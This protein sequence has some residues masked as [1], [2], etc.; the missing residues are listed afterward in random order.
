[1]TQLEKIYCVV[2]DTCSGVNELLELREVDTKY[3]YRLPIN[4]VH[5]AKLIKGQTY[6]FYKEHNGLGQGPK[7]SFIQ[8]G[9]EIGQTKELV[10]KETLNLNNGK[11]FILEND[12]GLDLKVKSLSFQSQHR[13]IKCQ[14]INYRF[15]KPILNNIDFD[16][17]HYLLDNDYLFDIV[18]FG[19]FI[20]KKGLS[21]N[22]VILKD[23]NDN[24]I[25]VRAKKWQTEK[26]WK[27]KN[28]KCKI[29]GY[30]QGEI[31]KVHNIDE[32]HPY[33]EVGDIIKFEVT[34]FKERKIEGEPIIRLI[35]LKDKYNYS[36]EV[37]LLPHQV[38]KLKIG[39]HIDCRVER[40]SH[41]V[42][43]KQVI[44]DD[45][46]F[47]DFKNIIQNSNH[48]KKYFSPQFELQTNDVNTLQMRGQYE[49]RSGFYILTF[50]NKILPNLFRNAIDRRDY[51]SAIEI[52]QLIID[53]EKWILKNGII[54]AFPNEL[55]RKTTRE[56]VKYS[57]ERAEVRAKILPAIENG[58]IKQIV[59]DLQTTI[60]SAYYIFL[61]SDIRLLDAIDF[62]KFI[63]SR[64]TSIDSL[65][66]ESRTSVLTKFNAILRSRKREFLTKRNEE[67][68]LALF[69]K[70]DISN[71]TNFDHY[72]KWTYL[73]VLLLQHLQNRSEA[74]ILKAQLLRS[75]A[76]IQPEPSLRNSLLHCAF[77]ILTEY[78]NEEF[79]LPLILSNRSLKV[80]Q[81]LL[82]NFEPKNI[83]N[84]NLEII[85]ELTNSQF[86][87]VSINSK[88]I[89]G[90]VINYKGLT[91]F[92]PSNH[93]TDLELKK[94]LIGE[95]S[96]RTNVQ[97][98][99]YSKE[100]KYFVARQ[101]PQEDTNYYSENQFKNQPV[102][103]EIVN[104]AV[105]TVVDYGVF[106]STKYGDGLLHNSKI[107][108]EPLKEPELKKL[109]KPGY[110][111]K[112][113]IASTEKLS[114]SVMALSD[115]I[116]KEEYLTLKK[117]I[118]SLLFDI[119]FDE[120]DIPDREASGPSY[121]VETEKGFILEQY[122]AGLNDLNEKINYIKLAKQFY[123]NHKN[124]R[125]YLLNIYIDYFNSILLLEE[126]INNYSFER[127][128]GLKEQ[129]NEV[130]NKIKPKTLENF[131]RIDRLIYFIN[132]LTLFNETTND[133]FNELI[134]YINKYSEN[135]DETVL[136][137]IAKITLSNNLM[138]SETL[139]DDKFSKNNL[140]RIG[141]FIRN[142]IF[143]L[144]ESE[145]D[146]LEREQQVKR[147]YWKDK[148][149]QDESATLE[150]KSTFIKPVPDKKRKAQIDSLT[151]SLETAA[152][153]S[154]ILQRIE[155][156]N[157][158]TA[159][160]AIIHSAFK[161]I[162]AFANTSGGFLLLGVSDDK[163]IYGLQDDYNTFKQE[164]RSRDGFGKF[165][166]A[167]L[168]EY[169]GDSFSSILLSKE[170]L[171]FPEGDVLII[172]VSPSVE[173]VYLLK[174]DLG[175]RSEHIYVR[176]LS[177]SE[178]LEGKELA[179][180][181]REKYRKQIYLPSEIP[182]EENKNVVYS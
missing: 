175:N 43:L 79:D 180:F 147:K 121:E 7:I 162:A 132:I 124:A 107:Y 177:S 8:P 158:L 122:A 156:I 83:S 133:S 57:I 97:M 27:Y 155:E 82:K 49:S 104:A 33:F 76:A 94:H 105:K 113:Q 36:H 45:P 38:E 44:H 140:K 9:F 21:V 90:F 182:A 68:F 168:N 1:M 65:D 176:N 10:I 112:V 116:Y 60:E 35:T 52:N 85:E 71:N 47:Y 63:E 4:Q 139:K 73:Q 141:D 154:S 128:N 99:N 108:S 5:N 165:F 179:R 39:E 28:L 34:G 77:Q 173:E 74:N 135:D 92:L 23:R 16:N 100:F 163:K 115:T 58:K 25:Q 91:G 142:G 62:I 24:E 15:G 119:Q 153:P 93:V 88:D 145:S 138:L 136:T 102:L 84:E 150:F 98:I 101:L 18:T 143:S 144:N 126:I 26:L 160:K 118:K 78:N 181:I 42:H 111:L 14:V 110:E 3:E 149:G 106:L 146:R 46:Y 170:F 51:K 161:T 19:T 70:T 59:T 37:I 123:V 50:C 13:T 166:D 61:Y 86:L 152:D 103:Y 164:D 169:F 127:Y 109:F 67:D 55:T 32:R 6:E 11:F 30:F 48:Q 2:E 29:S 117:R 81:G 137:T 178:K 172:E 87:E 114:F 134:G 157:G 31:P 131:S 167:K 72:N 69:E 12:L 125:S 17:H 56:K 96:W 64:L 159:Q 40:I 148:I 130:K 120:E 171:K 54:Q 75:Y 66:L 80:N 129:L 174:D 41:H 89:N 95:I 151:K 20:D 53:I 22:T